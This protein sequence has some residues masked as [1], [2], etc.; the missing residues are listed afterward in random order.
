M[1]D[2]IK[3]DMD[4]ME[5]IMIK[6]GDRSDIWQDRFIW[7]IAKAVYDALGSI[8]KMKVDIAMLEGEVL[9]AKH[10]NK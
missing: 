1:Q 8:V 7:A 5:D 9:N 6:L 10:S 3:K 4:N 2:K